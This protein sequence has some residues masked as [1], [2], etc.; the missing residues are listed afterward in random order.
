MEKIPKQCETCRD[1]INGH[2]CNADA[3]FY[4]HDFNDSFGRLNFG[5]AEAGTCPDWRIKTSEAWERFKGIP[6]EIKTTEQLTG[7]DVS[8]T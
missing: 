1:M 5:D 2:L 4:S 7:H 8:G 6:K 3:P